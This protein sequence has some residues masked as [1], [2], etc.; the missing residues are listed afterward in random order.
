MMADSGMREHDPDEV[1][2]PGSARA[3]AQGCTCPAARNNYGR[4]APFKPGTAVGGKRGGWV[5]S[6]GCPMHAGEP[7]KGVYLFDRAEGPTTPGPDS[8]G[9]E[10]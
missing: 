4:R 5:L 3:R 8:D 1:P 2:P 6:V 10:S 7:W 9:Q